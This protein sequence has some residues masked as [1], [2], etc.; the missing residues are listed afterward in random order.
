MSP[1]AISSLKSPLPYIVF[2]D[3]IF[4]AF[5][6]IPQT[7]HF[8]IYP[9]ILTWLNFVKTDATDLTF[10]F[11]FII[12][13]SLSVNGIFAPSSVIPTIIE[14]LPR[15]LNSSSKSSLEKLPT[16]E[17]KQREK[18][19]IDIPIIVIIVRVKFI[20]IFEKAILKLLAII[21]IFSLD[22][23]PLTIFYFFRY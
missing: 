13:D 15:L 10:E 6:S 8:E 20:F 21:S 19:E 18:T 23:Y 1:D 3:T 22:F 11:T 4:L 16:T 7:R 9:C 14:S 2:R 12:F 17:I 5:S